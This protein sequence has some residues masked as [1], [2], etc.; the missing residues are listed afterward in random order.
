M[1]LAGNSILITG[2][3]TGI[4]LGLARQLQERGNRV[5]ICG[6]RAEV[7]AAA[8][9]A[10]PGLSAIAADVATEGG[11]ER[12]LADALQM[13]PDLN[14]LVNNAGIQRRARFRTD[15]AGWPARAAE[16]RINL[17][18]PIHLAALFL[19]Q[20]ERQ[21]RAAIVNV[22][23]GLAFLP[24][25]FAP[26]YAASKAGLHSFTQA[27]R[28]ELQQTSVAV[29]DIIPPMVD[30]DLG[31][32]GIHGEGVPV[33][34]FVSAVLARMEAGETEIGYGQSEAFR[35]A[36]RAELDAIIRQINA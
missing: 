35:T 29:I 2:G 27:L 10:V 26:L 18:A 30:T 22:T 14:I 20:L 3:G 17:E 15:S 6:R 5:I 25:A 33:D 19:P 13:A 7:L 28:F 34:D 21:P 4:G 11:R 9:D 23:S 12:L 8:V 1:Q 31:G 32:S 36:G 16:L 24:V